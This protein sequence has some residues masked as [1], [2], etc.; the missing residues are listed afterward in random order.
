MSEFEP[1][2][3]DADLVGWPAETEP[4]EPQEADIASE[5]GSWFWAPSS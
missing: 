3:D 1:D 4:E 2:Y 5:Q